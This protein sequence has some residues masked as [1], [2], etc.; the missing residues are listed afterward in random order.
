MPLTLHVGNKRYSSWS[1]RPWVL[2]K[3][4]DIPFED[5]VHF[6]GGDFRARAIASFSPSG[7]VPSLHADGL[8]VTD[9]LAIVEFL[10]ED[11]P[12]VWP[13]DRTARAWARCAAA[14]MHAGFNALRGEHPMN[15]ALRFEPASSKS[16]ALAADI[17]KIDAMWSE[18]L[19]RFGGQWLAGES[20]TAV[21]AFYAP[22]ASRLQTYGITLSP[23]AEAYKE[24]VLAHPAVVAW[25]EDGLKEEAR[26]DGYEGEALLAQGRKLVKN[27]AP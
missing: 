3:A 23:H 7:K 9:S 27:L 12:A 22:V 11:Y 2:L 5:Q 19:D 6:M 8:I 4:L 20:F 18:G 21:D 1:M 17:E 24:R 26:L 25:V 10:A 13:A 16:T 14:E 15:V